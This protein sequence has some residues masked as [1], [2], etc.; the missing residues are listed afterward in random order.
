MKHFRLIDSDI[1]VAPLLAQVEAHPELWDQ[2]GARRTLG[3]PHF[4][5]PDI[6]VRYRAID[7]LTAPYRYAEP[8][9]STFYPAWDLLPGVHDIVFDVMAKARAVEL[10]AIFITKIPPG[11]TVLP[12]H[13]RGPWHS[14]FHNLKVYVPLKANPHCVNVCEDESVIMS[15]GECWS[16]DNLK[17][18]SVRND[19]DADRMTL[20]I[21]M[22]VE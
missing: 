5:V 20:I 6:W 17:V 2:H 19:G 11:K 22:R 12:H 18:H 16:F 4:D 15:A 3:S 13:D 1:D 9:H 14:E 21:C 10:G 8:F 7:E